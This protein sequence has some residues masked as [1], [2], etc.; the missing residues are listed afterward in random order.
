MVL[1][2]S[3]SNPANDILT[4]PNKVIHREG[5]ITCLQMYTDKPPSWHGV[6]PPYRGPLPPYP[7][8]YSVRMSV[9]G[10]YLIFEFVDDHLGVSQRLFLT[11]SSLFN[12][13]DSETENMFV[14]WFEKKFPNENIVAS[15]YSIYY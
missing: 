8:L 3:L 12:M 4:K 10:G 9:W 13:N 2:G 7:P 15:Y 14:R 5:G 11:I 1:H 6:H